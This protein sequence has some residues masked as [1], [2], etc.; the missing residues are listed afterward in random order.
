MANIRDITG[1]NREFTGTDSVQL[2]NGTTGE[3]V[4][5]GSGDK[6]KLRYNSTT[7]LAEYYNGTDWK[8]IDS[9]PTITGFTLDGGSTVTTA[10]IDNEASGTASI[11]IAGSLFDTTSGTVVFEANAGNNV[12]VQSITRTSANAFTVTVT[13]TDFLSAGSPYAIKLTNAS[14]LA[15]TLA[16]AITPDQAAPVFATSANTNVGSIARG[17]SDFSGFTTVAATDAD[18]DTITHTISAGS[19]PTGITLT[20]AG[21]LT[22]TVG[23]SATIQD[24][25]FTVSAATTFGTTTRQF[26]MTVPTPAGDS[27]YT[28]AGTYTFT[29]PAGV[30]NVSVVC[31]GA[32]GTN[33]IGN[34]GQAGA[35]AALAFRNGVSVTAGQTATVV[36]GGSSGRSGNNGQTGGSSSFQ[37]SGTTTT[38]GGGGGGG[39]DGAQGGSGGSGGTRSGTNNGGGNGGNGGTDNQNAG[40]PGGGGAGGYSGNGGAGAGGY[41]GTAST[42]GSGGSG[43]GGGGGGKGGTNE[44]GGGGG[45]GVGF[46]GEGSSGAG[47]TGSGQNNNGGGGAGAGSGGQ[48]G[49]TGENS[50][51][52]GQNSSGGQ[53]GA[54]G[55]GQGGTQSEGSNN[56]AGVGAV[57]IVWDPSGTAPAFPSTNVADR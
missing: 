5:S 22:G 16:A 14:G 15:A 49:G 23:G 37:Y 3:R 24:Y 48:A 1:K 56:S 19:L 7:N 32:G 41:A 47:G 6:G 13:R 40:G 17:G 27:E 33:G 31:I 52:G 10:E 35:G 36:V 30:S 51:A 55:G 42:N 21:A 29:V 53:G 43:G 8:P 38:A 44:G 25:T 9:P 54:Y 34:S 50:A 45:G 46:Y 4:A 18:S 39:G 20:T 26:V 11:V 57:R 12:N 28:T 2:P